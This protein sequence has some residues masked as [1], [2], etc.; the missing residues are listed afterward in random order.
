M[1]NIKYLNLFLALFFS[2]SVCFVGGVTLTG[3]L[4]DLV[5]DKDVED[6]PVESVELDEEETYSCSRDDIM[7]QDEIEESDLEATFEGSMCFDVVLS[8]EP[9]DVSDNEKEDFFSSRCESVGATVLAD[10]QTCE[11]LYENGDSCS[12]TVSF[13]EDGFETDTTV[14]FSDDFEVTV[15]DNSLEAVDSV[16]ISAYCDTVEDASEG[17]FTVEASEEFIDE[18]KSDIEEA[19]EDALP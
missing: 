9:E 11:D 3:C 18:L 8:V 15:D 14:W 10:D 12:E 6:P 1:K 17:E 19:I 16:V 4:E 2:L 5:E 7:F 13:D